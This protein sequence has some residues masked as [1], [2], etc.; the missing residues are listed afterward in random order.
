METKPLKV[1]DRVVWI[2]LD[3]PIHATV[4]KVPSGIPN[5]GVA[6]VREDS[7]EETDVLVHQDGRLWA[8]S[9]WK[10]E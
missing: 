7:G 8:G 6:R 2:G 3:G 9:S 1:G 5:Q 4:I 10:V